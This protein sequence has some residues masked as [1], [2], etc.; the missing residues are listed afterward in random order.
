MT[1]DRTM[2][3]GSIEYLEVVFADHDALDVGSFSLDSGAVT[4][5]LDEGATWL[6]AAWVNPAFLTHVVGVGKRAARTARTL[7]NTGPLDRGTYPVWS[8]FVD[9]P[10]APID[11]NGILRVI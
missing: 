4:L 7:L 9:A 1:D 2:I 11:L 10:E 6:T 5:S 8:K 3:Q